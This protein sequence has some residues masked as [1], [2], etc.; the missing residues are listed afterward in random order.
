M[1]V[2]D[3]TDIAVP[4]VRRNFV[5]S[6]ING[7]FVVAGN[8]AIDPATVIPLLVLRLLGAEWAVGLAAAVQQFARVG[9]QI[10]AARVLDTVRHKQ[11]VYAWTA[12]TRTICMCG[13]TAVLLWGVG[14]DPRL[15]LTGLLLALFGLMVG[16]GVSGLAWMDLNARSVP[17]VRRGSLLAYRRAIGLVLSLVISAPLVRYLLGSSSPFEFPANYGMLFLTGTVL[18]AIAWTSFSLVRE[19]PVHAAR[20]RLTLRQHLVRGVRIYQR[21]RTYRRLLRMKILLGLTSAVP[22]FFIAFACR[23]LGMPEHW[24]AVFLTTQLISE[25]IG[26][27]V[28]GRLSDRAGNRSVMVASAWVGC[29]TFLAATVAAMSA[30]GTSVA[31][32]PPVLATAMI[33]VAFSGLGILMSARGAGEINYMLD[34]APAAKRPSY[35]GFGNAILLPMSLIPLVVGWLIPRSGYLPV[36]AISLGISLVSVIAAMKLEEPRDTLMPEAEN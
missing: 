17:S 15:V 6:V 33:A 5:L 1:A 10:I 24:A 30:W 14:R 20:H 21:D 4:L 2:R 7:A 11:R 8:R 31:D 13:A 19:P 27:L 29:A 23:G 18:C 16:S 3:R 28:F 34:I 36:F 12:V 9:T 32:G 35:I 26:S 22:T 25:G